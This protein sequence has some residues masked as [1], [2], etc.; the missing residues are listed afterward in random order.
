MS[1][2]EVDHELEELNRMRFFKLPPLKSLPSPEADYRYKEIK[3]QNLMDEDPL[4]SVKIP[5]DQYVQGA[6]YKM[7]NCIYDADGNFLYRFTNQ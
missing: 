7:N 2:K 5:P 1:S 4:Q 3:S 6:I